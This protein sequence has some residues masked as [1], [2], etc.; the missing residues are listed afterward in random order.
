MPILGVGVYQIPNIDECE[1]AVSGAILVGYRVI[2]TA[3]SYKYE[4][5]V[6]N[7]IRKSGIAR[8]YFF[9]PTTIWISNYGYEKAKASLDASLAKLQPNYIELVLLHQPFGD[10]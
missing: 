4:E 2:D 10:Y 8:E 1:R 9:M 6:G 7:A 5:A 3:Q